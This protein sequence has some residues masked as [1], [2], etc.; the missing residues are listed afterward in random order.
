MKQG[1]GQIFS[2]EHWKHQR[3]ERWNC[4][5]R[6]VLDKTAAS[7]VGN[8]VITDV[9]GVPILAACSNAEAYHPN[10]CHGILVTVP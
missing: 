9:A 2:G 8:T 10:L 7:G 5:E 1:S 6:K 3:T 4:A